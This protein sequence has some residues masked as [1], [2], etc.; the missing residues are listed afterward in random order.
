MDTSP[1]VFINEADALRTKVLDI[2]LLDTQTGVGANAGRKRYT[3]QKLGTGAGWHGTHGVGLEILRIYWSSDFYDGD[4]TATNNV[5][6][7]VGAERQ[8]TAGMSPATGLY[9]SVTH[10]FRLMREN[11]ATLATSDV[12]LQADRT[13][14]SVY[15]TKHILFCHDRLDGAGD[16]LVDTCS[17]TVEGQMQDLTDGAGHGFVITNPSIVLLGETIVTNSSANRRWG[18]AAGINVRVSAKLVCRPVVVDLDTF[19]KCF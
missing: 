6:A 19:H 3:Q 11:P 7:N 4:T 12:D 1:V 2:T 15:R 8:F 13:A 14:F 5:S 17:T 16:Q 18:L 9:S 10:T